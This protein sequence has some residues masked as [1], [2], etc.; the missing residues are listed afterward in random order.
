MRLGEALPPWNSKD[1]KCCLYKTPYVPAPVRVLGDIIAKATPYEQLP[2]GTPTRTRIFSWF[3]KNVFLW[4]SVSSYI[5]TPTCIFYKEINEQK[6]YRKG[7]LITLE[8]FHDKYLQVS[9]QGFFALM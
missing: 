6:W 9:H 7:L 8:E 3:A 1:K 5:K 4:R 2:L